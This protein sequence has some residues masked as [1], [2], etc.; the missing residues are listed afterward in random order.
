MRKTILTIA[1]SALGAASIGFAGAGAASSSPGRPGN[2]PTGYMQVNSATTT[3]TAPASS[4]VAST[5]AV[6]A[7]VFRSPFAALQRLDALDSARF[8]GFTLV[9][10]PGRW[11]NRYAVEHFYSRRAGAKAEVRNLRDGG[12]GAL[13]ER[14]TS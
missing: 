7:G 5:F 6:V 4:P 12:F 11:G 14:V 13:I 9:A 1:I 3:S 10:Q 8:G 2:G